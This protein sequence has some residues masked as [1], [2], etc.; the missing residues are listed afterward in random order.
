MI[1]KIEKLVSIG[2]YRDYTAS[3][4]VNFKK[5]TLIYGDNGGGKTTLTSVFRSLT[6]DNPSII[7]SRISTAHTQNQAAQITQLG[8]PNIYHTFGASGWTRPFPNIEIF[9]ISAFL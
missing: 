1:N 7:K 6:S 4:Q 2:K 3:G 5:L 9:D 8:T